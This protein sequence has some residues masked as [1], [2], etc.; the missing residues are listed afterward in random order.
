M[1]WDSAFIEKTYQDRIR[2]R[3]LAPMMARREDNL[4]KLTSKSLYGEKVHY[5]LE[6]IQNAED[7]GASTITFIFDK[8]RLVVVN[9]G[10]VFQPDDVDAICSV[11][12]GRKKNKIGFFGIGFKS[13]FNITNA[14]QVVS[15]SSNFKIENFIYPRPVDVLPEDLTPYYNKD[16]GAIFIFPQAE[17]SPTIQELIEN[18]KEI[19]EKILLFLENLKT[20]NFIDNLN[21][22]KWSIEKPPA[23]DSIVSLKNGRTNQTTKWKVFYKDLPVSGEKVPIPE[24]KEGITDTRVLIAFPADEETREASKASTVYCY[25]PTNKRSDMPFLVQADFVPTVGRASIQDVDWNKWLLGKLG[26]LAA[27]AIEQIRD[28]QNLAKELYSFIPL[29]DE[30]HE[31]LMSILSDSIYEALRSKKVSK[32]LDHDWKIPEES[33]ITAS[34]EVT[35]IISQED[36]KQLFG[37]PLFYADTDLPERAQQILTDLGSLTL[38]DEEFVEFLGKEDLVKSR[39]PYWF[40]HV[41]AYLNEVFDVKETNYDGSFAWEEDKLHLFSKLEKT[42]FILTN[43]GN[44][45]PLKDPQKPDRLIC[46]PQSIDLSEVNE[47]FT[48]GELVFLNR[49][50]Q[51]STIAKRKETDPEEEKKRQKVHDFFDGVGVKLDFKQRHAIKDVI[52]P[53]YS[54]GKYKEYD[55]LKLY[56]LI[57]YIRMYWPTLQSEVKNK[58]L[59]EDIFDEIKDTVLLKTYSYKGGERVINY[60]PPKKLYFPKRYG[61]SE[62]MEDLFEGLEDVYFLD[63]YY[64]NREKREQKKKKRGRQKAEFGWKKFAE[65]L[66][67]WS[68]PRVEKIEE[69]INISGKKEYDWVERKYSPS[70]KHRILGDS[71]SDDVQKLINYLSGLEEPEKVRQ[72]ITILCQSLSDNWKDYKKFCT[73]TYEYFYHS[74]TPINLQSST[75]LEFLKRAKWVPATDGN[76]CIPAEVFLDSK[77]NKFLL[78]DDV[79]FVNLAVSQ[80]FLKDIGVKLEPSTEQVIK[81]FKETKNKAVDGKKRE[82]QKFEEIYSFISEKIAEQGQGNETLET[83]QKDF[84]ENELI[85]IPRKDQSWWKPS[86]VFWRDYSKTLGLLRGYVEHEGKEIYPANTKAFF[87][88]LGVKEKPSIEQALG[89]LE[90]LRQKNDIETLKRIVTKV[91]LYISDLLSHA[92]SEEVEWQKYHFLTKK[93]N[94]CPPAGIYYEDD[95]EYSK[96]FHG[97]AEFLYLPFSSW[98]NLSRFLKAAGFKSFSENLSIIKSL[99]AVTEME[100]GKAE[101]LIRALNLA[102]PYLL[103]K[104]IESYEKLQSE[105]TFEKLKL[106]EVYEAPQIKLDL[107]LNKNESETLT[108]NDLGKEAYYSQEENRLYVLKGTD[109]FSGAI[110][111]EASRIFKGLENDVFPFLS[112][113]LTKANDEEALEIQLRLFGIQKE[114][115][116]AYSGPAKV[117]LLPEE[118]KPETEKEEAKGTEAPKGEEPTVEP[119]KTPEPPRGLIDPDE[120]YPSTGKEYTPYNKTEGEAPK[121]VKEI[122][123]KEGKPG[124]SKP[125][126]EE[127]IRAGTKDSESTAIQIVLN[128]ESGEGGAAEDR[129]KQKGIGYDVYSKTA[130]GEERFIEIKG[131]REK[132]GPFNLTPHELEKARKE[133][134]KY[135]VYVVSGLKEGFTPKKLFIIQNP[136]R[137]LTPDPPIKEEYS[138][139]KN[140]VKN[141]FEFEKA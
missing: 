97:K 102:G 7:A 58:R 56:N 87:L 132:E 49:Y 137:W 120:Y 72:R 101:A 127:T 108:V 95:E 67:V 71:F 116:E 55:D 114:E 39:K 19:D 105:G 62:V 11:E 30:V 22:D 52:L 111:K 17:G 113:I 9:D 35:R 59:S 126:R 37:K 86:C 136:T 133:C 88:S 15:S 29:K 107:C 117:E 60:L 121:V 93:G 4:F 70:G 1:E 118:P 16:K 119:P 32:I 26:N 5:A 53:K 85:Y 130:D 6:L 140:A 41:Y 66:G 51:L 76:F 14:P 33:V 69:W 104:N 90:E 44:L 64:L 68:S 78:G 129:H 28:D 128:Y 57:N 79:N 42:K 8:E 131:F 124:I 18:F 82:I 139:W 2:E 25:L 38:G 21:G 99:G 125:T 89:I 94:Y 123:L 36:L 98:T 122:K 20:L 45:V 10:D 83:I 96:E 80:D 74:P 31:P 46:Y 110:A 61:P 13:V 100:A 138:D 24:G 75:F 3:E 81:H 34:P 84:E 112:S 141:E 77:R 135:Y 134:D 27:G 48:E 103:H 54:S 12:P 43:Q 50:F 73:L 91:Y 109:L 106:L 40:L 115:G 63:P 92:Q 65:M 23:D 47:L